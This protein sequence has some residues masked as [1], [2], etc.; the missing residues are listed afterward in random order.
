VQGS[1]EAIVDT[2]TR[3]NN[4]E[5]SVDIIRSG[6]GGITENDVMLAAASSAVI[7]GFRVRPDIRARERAASTGVDIQT[8]SIIYDVEDTVRKALSGLLKPERRE[9]FIG[10]AEVRQIFRVPKVGSIAGCYVV[11]GTVRRNSRF[12]LVRAGVVVWEGTLSSLRHVKD[13]RREV[14]AGYECG[15]GLDGYSDM[16]LGDIIECYEVVEVSRAL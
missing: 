3:M 12:R 5:V 4:E 9:E 10:S 8:F 14:A 16:K 1:S 6:A 2:L 13:D 11:A 7:V 15:I